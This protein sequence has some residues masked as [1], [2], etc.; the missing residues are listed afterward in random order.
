MSIN[1]QS[2]NDYSFLFQNLGTSNSG[3]AANLNFLSD[4]ASI[5]NGSYAK[6]MKAY[7][8][9]DKS[10]EVSSLAEKKTTS[11][12]N[13]DTAKTL[14]KM[15][16]TTDALKESADKLLETGDKSVFTEDAVT[17]DSYKSVSAF[18]DDYNAV[19]S[20]A[21]DVNSTSIL[22]KTLNMINATASNEDLLGR[23]G[24]T[25]EKDNT[26]S[27][28]KD[29]FMKAAAATVKSLFQ[30]SGSFAYRVSA[31][32]SLINF[33]ADNEAAKA[34]TYTQNGTYGNSFN[35]GSIFNSFF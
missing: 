32:S 11:A 15:Q 6:L 22:N 2:K 21:D 10:S 30:G 35:T 3:A 1:I 7:Y 33:A 29:A 5:K 20:A 19:L 26:L 9:K 4:Y 13:S 12:E 31:Q 23:A 14:S 27:L 17:E 16:S 25:I 18:I 8:S 28:D 34:D 24:I